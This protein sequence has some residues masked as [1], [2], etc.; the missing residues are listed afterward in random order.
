MQSHR[1]E[2]D[3]KVADGIVS[4]A[5]ES[6]WA[7]LQADTRA[8]LLRVASRALQTHDEDVVRAHLPELVAMMTGEIR[9]H[10]SLPRKPRTRALVSS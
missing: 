8:F 1:Y 10:A 7:R 4:K 9:P 5:N 3:T 2:I 6:A